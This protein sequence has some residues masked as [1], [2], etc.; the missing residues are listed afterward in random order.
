[1]CI[2]YSQLHVSISELNASCYVASLPYNSTGFTFLYHLGMHHSDALKVMKEG[3]HPL[4][5]AE[6]WHLENYYI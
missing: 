4:K 6:A 2:L 3:S 5:F 1:M